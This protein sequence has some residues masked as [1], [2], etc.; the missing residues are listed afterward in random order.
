[1]SQRRG[2]VTP[3]AQPGTGWGK[4]PGLCPVPPFG[5][6]VCSKVLHGLIVTL[7]HLRVPSQTQPQSRGFN[8]TKSTGILPFIPSFVPEIKE[9]FC[10]LWRTAGASGK[11]KGKQ[12]LLQT[13]L[14]HLSVGIRP[15]TANT[16]PSSTQDLVQ[17][18]SSKINNEQKLTRAHRN[19]LTW[20]TS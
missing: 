17:T 3:W 15:G 8:G 20:I 12:T 19:H 6:G 2:F 18:K 1:M 7:T 10:Q 16:C 9:D 11:M 14:M 13:P 5:T 4:G